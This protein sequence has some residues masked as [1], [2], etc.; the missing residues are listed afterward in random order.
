M[1]LASYAHKA[2]VSFG[3]IQGDVIRD[4]PANCSDIKDIV[5]LKKFITAFWDKRQEIE[6]QIRDCPALP[7]EDVRLLSPIRKPAR[8]FA[9]AGNYQKHIEESKGKIGMYKPV[10]QDA[11]P[12]VFMMPAGVIA[13]TGDEIPW[14]D[15]S[16]QI[17]YEIELAVVI[18]RPC[19]SITPD[20]A[21]DYIAGYT[22]CNDVSARSVTFKEG[23]TER[24]WDDFFDWLNGKWADGFFPTGPCL[25][26]PDEINDVQ[27]LD[28]S[29]KVNGKKRQESNTS[30]M[31]FKVSEIISFIS[32]MLTLEAGDIIATGTPEGVA[33]ATG[34]F[35][36]TGDKIECTIEKI[37]TINN[38]IGKKPEKFYSPLTK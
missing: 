10:K 28:M 1:K 5:S 36:K 23:R 21:M 17:D 4:L 6:N 15:Y 25:V 2:N 19:K 33:M 18:S 27:S 7:L 35:L 32:Q 24:P 9:L 29:L 3:I 38:V 12:R 31:I 37:G 8:I 11:T 22:V 26:T 14:P 20:Q 30:N 13:G 34:D 16:E